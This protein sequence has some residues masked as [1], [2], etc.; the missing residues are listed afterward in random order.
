MTGRLQAC[1]SSRAAFSNLPDTIPVSLLT[2]HDLETVN[3]YDGLGE[4]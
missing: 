1:P 4:G 3:V 2:P